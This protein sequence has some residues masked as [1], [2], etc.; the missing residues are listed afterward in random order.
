MATTQHIRSSAAAVL[1]VAASLLAAHVDPASATP[2]STCGGTR[3]VLAA[4]TP[5]ALSV[6]QTFGRTLAVPA[7][8]SWP[9]KPFDRQHP[10]RANLN[11][12]RIGHE[13]GESFHFG[14][15]I[16]VPDGT[17]VY[18]VTGGKAYVRPG[19]VSVADGGT[20]SFGYWHVRAAVVNHQPVR[21]HQLLG[22]V[23][24]GWEHV[25][26]AERANGV[27]LNPLRPGGLGPYTD[28]SAPEI[29]EITLT[30]LAGGGVQ[31]LA[32]T[33]DTPSP[34]VRGDWTHE[35]VSPALIQWRVFRNGRAVAGWQT[36]ADFRTRMLDR[37][38][39]ESVYAPPTRQN[40]KGKAGLYCFFLSHE[41]KPADGT[42]RIEVAASDTRENRTVAR[43][44]FTVEH[45]QVQS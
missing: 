21:R 7:A 26:F 28:V 44:D 16:S 23:I 42:Y 8:Y 39:F 34:R 22:W 10:V 17:P 37:K 4:D 13:G 35:P 5:A 9:V 45:G 38:L 33:Y 41:W 15:D 27:Y 36:A 24:P 19:N 31:V 1:L 40:H 14:I 11:D 12:P 30:H 25:H 18:A 20:H 2:G 43:L 29:G 6:T 32:N 3:T